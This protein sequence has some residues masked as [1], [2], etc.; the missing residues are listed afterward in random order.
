MKHFI[1]SAS[2]ALSSLIAPFV[3]HA[4]TIDTECGRSAFVQPVYAQPGFAQRA[5]G[6]EGGERFEGERMH[7]FDRDR[8]G[9]RGMHERGGNSRWNARPDRMGGHEGRERGWVRD[10]G[11]RR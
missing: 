4:G 5:Y 6:R 8:D 2:L 3:A 9:D 7:R 11:S 10:R 1:L